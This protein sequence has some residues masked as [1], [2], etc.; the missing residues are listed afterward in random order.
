MTDRDSNSFVVADSHTKPQ[1]DV[2]NVRMELLYGFAC[3]RPDFRA[4]IIIPQPRNALEAA[5]WVAQGFIR[6][7][8]IPAFWFALAFTAFKYAI[9]A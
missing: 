1:G 4:L 2:E 5:W 8:L 7:V 3:A 6:E 9:L